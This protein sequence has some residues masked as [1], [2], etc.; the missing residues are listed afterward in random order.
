MLQSPKSYALADSFAGQWLRVRDLYTS[1]RPDPR[2]Y[3][4]FTPSLRDAMY[5]ETIEFFY[6]LLRDDASLLNL[7]DANYTYL[8]EELARH[9]GIEG[10]QGPNMRRVYLT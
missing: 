4:G 3:P 5:Q 1:A 8:N 7:L 2:R 6:S 10:V 9:Y